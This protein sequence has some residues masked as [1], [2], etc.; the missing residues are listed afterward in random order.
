MEK[1][2]KIAAKIAGNMFLG[3]ALTD[4]LIE[5]V[6]SSSNS[7]SEAAKKNLESLNQEA[8]R[9]KIEMDLAL[10]HS[11]VAQELAIAQRIENAKTVEIEEFYDISGKGQGGLAVDAN[12]LTA[13]LGASGERSKV[14]KRVYRFTGFKQNPEVEKIEQEVT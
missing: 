8:M 10:Q 11:R 2:A 9:Q 1:T 14:S 7:A 6:E 13:S 5:K 4:F 3:G 12:S